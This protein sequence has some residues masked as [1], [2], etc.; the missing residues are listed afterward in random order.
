MDTEYTKVAE[1]IED[2]L[3]SKLRGLPKENQ[4]QALQKL[5]V[6]M[7]VYRDDLAKKLKTEGPGSYGNS[8]GLLEKGKKHLGQ[9][10]TK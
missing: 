1:A 8:Q 2:H 3:E 9:N 10:P 5:I 7:E 4:K 6:L